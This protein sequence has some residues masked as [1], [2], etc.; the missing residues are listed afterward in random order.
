MLF[1]IY[2][3]FS[4]NPGVVVYGVVVLRVVLESHGVVVP[5][6]LPRWAKTY[7]IK[8]WLGNQDYNIYIYILK[9][10]GTSGPV[11]STIM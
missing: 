6:K 5:K 4:P 9:K 11:A 3:S 1:H 2:H 7:Q 8:C 10:S